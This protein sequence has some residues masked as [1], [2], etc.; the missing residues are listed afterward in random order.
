M[1]FPILRLALAIVSF[2]L[3]FATASQAQFKKLYELDTVTLRSPN[4][5]K[6]AQLVETDLPGR[7]LVIVGSFSTQDSGGGYRSEMFHLFCNMKGEP[8]VMHMYEDTSVFAFQ[9]PQAYAAC[10]DGNGVIYTGIGANSRQVVFKANENGQ[11]L[12]SKSGNHHEYYSILCEG[13]Q[14]TFLGQDESVQGVHDFSLGRLDAA[15]NGGNGMMY[16][17]PEFEI[18]QRVMKAGDQY[19]AVGQAFQNPDFQ[20][21]I[22][23]AAASLEQIWGKQYGINGKGMMLTGVSQPL[24]GHGYILSGRLRG[25]ADSLLLMKIDT[26][27]TPIWAKAY[28]IAGVSE[29]MNSG[30]AVDP[31]SGGYILSGSYRGA[32]YFRPFMFMTDSIGNLRWA[33]DYAEPGV[34]TDETFNDLIYHKD[35]ELFIA[36]GDMVA[37]D[38]N[39]FTYKLLMVAV[40]ADS[41]TVPCDSAL[42]MG[43]VA[44]TVV[45]T[46]ST[47]QQP[48]LANNHF[49]I[50]NMFA[51]AMVAETRCT[52]IVGIAEHLPATGI[53]QILNPSGTDLQV[54]AD[55]LEGGA[56]LRVTTLAGETVLNRRLDEGVFQETIALPHLSSGMYLV[57]ISGENWRYPSRRW[58][59]LR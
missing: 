26:A 25:G 50:G 27:G 40:D 2:T 7:E 24:D 34:N 54:R 47:T 58:V 1:K 57:S 14:V 12:W 11:M 38:S 10:Y 30:L 56:N 43:M 15:G 3:L 36:A 55:V 13:G 29:A 44:R 4:F 5:F 52:V 19:V 39:I 6:V 22:V 46:G 23:K 9:A 41:G 49:P 20:G 45:A 42:T 53:F 37:I 31:V 16:G 51:G 35:R 48:F 8:Q 21:I 17:T 18:P 59:V 33:R 28:G 32:S